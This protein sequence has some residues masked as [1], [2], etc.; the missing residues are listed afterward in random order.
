MLVILCLR[1]PVCVGYMLA[2]FALLCSILFCF[3]LFCFALFRAV[4][5]REVYGYKK[6]EVATNILK[7][8]AGKA[9]EHGEVFT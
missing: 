8:L 2:C 5:V 1:L 4:I 9:G 3:V 6:V 7:V